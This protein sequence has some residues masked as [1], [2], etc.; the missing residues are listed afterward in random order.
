MTRASAVTS[1]KLPDTS[2]VPSARTWTSIADF[3]DQMHVV[4]DD[5]EGNALG[6]QLADQNG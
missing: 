2:V 4:F 6:L 5:A 3:A 1:A